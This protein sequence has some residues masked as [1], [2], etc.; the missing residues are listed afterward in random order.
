MNVTFETNI[1]QLVRTIKARAT[2]VH[3]ALYQT[4][5]DWAK[6]VKKEL[7]TNSQGAIPNSE[8]R[9]MKPGLYSTA[10]DVIPAFDAL[11]N[12][13]EENFVDGWDVTTDKLPGGTCT[14]F[15]NTAPYSGYME[16]P[17]EPDE[18]RKKMRRRPIIEQSIADAPPLYPLL[19]H[20][21]YIVEQAEM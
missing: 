20:A 13:Q 6:A 7:I 15:T 8:L 11:I 3:N 2:A 1:N 18:P 21:K 5:K 19:K 16:R 9:K 12:K 14:T 4:Q 10:R 17:G